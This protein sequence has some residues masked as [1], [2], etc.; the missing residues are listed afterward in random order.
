M[1]TKTRNLVGTGVLTAVTVVLTILSSTVRFGPFSITLALIPIVIG[2]AIYG[3]KAG[4]WL[5]LVFG[6]VVLFTDAG[7]FMAISPI[8]TI[9]T[10]LLK[11]A[12]AGLLAGVVYKALEKKNPVVAVIVAAI[13][14]PIANTGVF[15]IGCTV[16]FL[17][18]IKEWAAGAGFDSVLSY[19]IVGFVGINF[20]VEMGTNIILSSVIT[21]ILK[22]VRKDTQK[23]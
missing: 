9:I 12:A 14:A 6:F 20:L 5:G 17:D 16:F 11:G 21:R 1:N 22:I 4:T 2:S 7:A 3:V 23:A 18:T 10:C 8:G 19:Y 15:L 13:A